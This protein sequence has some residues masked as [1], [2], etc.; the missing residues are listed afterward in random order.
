MTEELPPAIRR[1]VEDVRRREDADGRLPLPDMSDWDIFPFEGE[2]RVK[3]LEAPVFP[4]PARAGEPGG[5]PCFQCSPRPEAVL[6]EAAHWRLTDP[7][8]RSVPAV[9]LL[10]TVE[11]VDL[12]TL[13]PERAL[14]LG[15]LTCRIERAVRSVEGVGRVHVYRYGDGS[16]HFHLCV[17]RSSG[18][19]RAD[20]R[21]LPH[22]LGGRASETVGGGM[23]S[24]PPSPQGRPRR[25]G[26]P[27][28]VG[29]GAG[30]RMTNGR[31]DR[32]R[33]L[34]A[35]AAA[36]A[37]GAAGALLS[38]CSPTAKTVQRAA[39]VEPAGSD[40]GAI[41]HVVMLMQENRSF[42]HYFGTYQ[43]S[44]RVRRPP[45]R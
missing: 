37:A 17:L 10:E 43:G 19:S 22:D 29:P 24:E 16:A 26:W 28:G 13:P 2:M 4:E 44:A 32:R 23:A 12:D 8:P 7:G 6:L 25:R 20:P 36:G 5:R 33:F 42:D 39:A 15:P 34:G 27:P 41:E 1:V 11:H 3:R 21:L 31:M 35:A 30:H 18:R 38:A 14:E 40:L 9:V 45:G